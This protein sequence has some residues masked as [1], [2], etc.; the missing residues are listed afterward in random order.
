MLK[1][2]IIFLAFANDRERHL[3][4]LTEEARRVEGA[5]KDADDRQLCKV[6]RKDNA[7]ILDILTVLQDP[8]NENRVA[9]FH[10]GGHADDSQLLFEGLDGQ[11]APVEMARLTEVLRKQQQGLQLVFLNGCSTQ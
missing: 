5:L 8:A 4:N 9:V 10:F 7:S 3:R 6:I 1:P 11:P 2:P